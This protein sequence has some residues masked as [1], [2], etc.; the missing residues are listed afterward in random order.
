MAF[1]VT[2]HSVVRDLASADPASRAAAYDALV[3]SY[4]RPVYLYIRWRATREGRDAR[5]TD[6]AQDLT[7][8]FFTR[9]FERE[10]L[11][12]YDASKARFRTF[13]RTC[14]DAF[15]AND[16]RDAGRLKRG[17]GV[18]FVATDF[19]RADAGLAAHATSPDAD[20][21]RWFHQ[22]WIRGVFADALDA[23]RRRCA[24]EQRADAFTIFR[25]YDVDDEA[26]PRPTYAGLARDLGLTATDVTNELAWARRSFRA[27]VLD[28][29][30]GLCATDEEFRTEARDLLGVDPP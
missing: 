1:P 30:R 10:Y 21:E 15:L 11:E 2:R 25:R 29:L 5:E 17:G 8:E 19:A 20:P 9:A 26:G 24:A 23:L 13:V 3:R 18:T 6:D 7:Q 22:E 12:R 16:A 28:I 14:L 4:W 27:I